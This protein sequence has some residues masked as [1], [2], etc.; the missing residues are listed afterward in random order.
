MKTFLTQSVWAWV[1]SSYRQAYKGLKNSVTIIDNIRNKC[2]FSNILKK[3]TIKS[4]I[5]D[6]LQIIFT[7]HTGKSQSK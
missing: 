4:D 2:L 3:A 1:Y 6:Q 5:S 7:I